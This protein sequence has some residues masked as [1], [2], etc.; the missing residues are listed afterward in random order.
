MK[1]EAEVLRLFLLHR[2]QTM[3][4]LH[5]SSLPTTLRGEKTAFLTFLPFCKLS[6]YTGDDQLVGVVGMFVRFYFKPDFR[7]SV[8]GLSSFLLPLVF[9]LMFNI[10][11]VHMKCLVH[12]HMFQTH[13][14]NLKYTRNTWIFSVMVV[15]YREFVEPVTA[16]LNIFL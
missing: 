7:L 1:P 13:D 15:K 5:G 12:T 10:I 8:Q 9:S 6:S 11:T 16:T 4:L 14:E 2:L 3:L